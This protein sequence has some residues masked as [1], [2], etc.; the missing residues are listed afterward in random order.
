LLRSC[1]SSSPRG[2]T[3]RALTAVA[4]LALGACKPSSPPT[5]PQM[6]PPEVSVVSVQPR[7]IPITL[8]Y[9]GRTEGVRETEVRPR[10]A[11][12]LQRW[13]Y[14]EGSTVNAGQS[15]FT[16][17]PAPFQA[18]VA[19]AEADLASAKARVAQ[20]QRDL[21]RLK[22]LLDQGMVSR[23]AYDDAI[24]ADEVA[25]AQ[26]QGA[27]AALREARLNLEYTR[28]EAPIS[29]VT[30]RAL[31]SE[32]SLVEAQNTLLTT[33][34]QIDP[35]R[36]IFSMSEAERLRFNEQAAAGKVRLP[37]DN[38]F[39]ATLQ[40][41]DGST[42]ERAG[43]VEF[44]DIRVD[45]ATGTTEFRAVLPNSDHRIRPGQF[46]RVILRGAQHVQALAVPQRAVLEGPQG[47]IVFVID[48]KNLAHPRPVQVGEWAGEDWVI[49]DGL[50]PG[51]RV[52]VDGVVKIRPGAPVTIAAAPGAPPSP[53]AAKP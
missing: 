7:D 31:K 37:R 42:S 39:S 20:A 26:L 8:E 3:G 18:I 12:I 13:N 30:S 1:H 49:K 47:K 32:G 5:P 2:L 29:G 17:D 24:A 14:T 23:K 11:G 27:E 10:V 33:I 51:E 4:A 9:V 53:A 28:V 16:I 15:L 34:S 6:P 40:L 43:V 21:E 45:P 52:V 22:P 38:R 36:V 25:R 19:R 35:I 48:D 41:P 50:K 44:S 46:V